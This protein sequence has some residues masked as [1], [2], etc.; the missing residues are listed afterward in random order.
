M[1]DDSKYDVTEIETDPA[2]YITGPRR[3]QANRTHGGTTQDGSVQVLR[4]EE[5]DSEPGQTGQ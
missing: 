4:V 2:V 5:P 1:T 3:G